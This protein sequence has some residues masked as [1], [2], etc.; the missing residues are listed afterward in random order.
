MTTAAFDARAFR[1]CLGMYAT[2]VTVMTA[3]VGDQKV[4]VTANSFSSLSLDPP[5]ILWSIARTSRSF[6][7]FSEA[8]HFAVNILSAKQIEVSQ[9]FAT[10][11]ADKFSGVAWTAGP[12][13]APLIDGVVARIECSTEVQHDGGDHVLIVG[14]VQ[15][16]AQFDGAPLLFAQGRY[17]IAEDH[18][19]MRARR[20]PVTEAV[21]EA[22][23]PEGRFMALLFHAY[24]QAGRLFNEQ[25]LATGLSIPMGRALFALEEMPGI[26]AER[27][28]RSMYL[29]DREAEDAVNEL[30]EAGDIARTGASGLDLTDAGRGRL[31][32]LRHQLNQFQID[33]L[34]GVPQ[35]EIDSGSRLLERIVSDRRRG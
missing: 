12:D 22:A 30:I 32:S 2:G 5:L 29:G 16:F 31:A 7:V 11:G 33:F 3:Q 27:L 8:R 34:A 20:R 25:R 24:H 6:A 9:L 13:G 17:G 15:R 10:S 28:A 14:R 26:T 4:G 23:S 21:S 18:P 35:D 19:D 1:G